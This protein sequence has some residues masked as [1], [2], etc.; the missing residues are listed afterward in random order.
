MTI[1]ALGTSAPE[2]VVNSVP[3]QEWLFRVTFSYIYFH[4]KNPL[5]LKVFPSLHPTD[6]EHQNSNDD[7]L[8]LMKE[9][10]KKYDTLIFTLPIY[11]YSMSGIM[12]VFFDRIA[13]LLTFEKELGRQLRGKK[14]AGIS[15]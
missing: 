8:K 9:I 1:V 3:F 6:Y 4:K 5:R 13:D 10:I 11:W 7:Y 15:C 2:L 12:K 14:M